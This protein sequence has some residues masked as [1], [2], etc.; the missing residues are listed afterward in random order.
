MTFDS[1][2]FKFADR[3]GRVV[4]KHVYRGTP[5][6]EAWEDVVNVAKPAIG[7]QVTKAAMKLPIEQ[8]LVTFAAEYA[9]LLMRDNAGPAKKVNGLWFGLVE[10][11]HCG[12][13][14]FSMWAPYIS[15][16]RKFKLKNHDWPCDPV[17]FVED[18]WAEN[19]PMV[20]LSS[21]RKKFSQRSWY[22]DVC[23]VEPLHRL[24]VAHFARACP[25]PILLGKSKSRGIGCGFDAGD[26][27]TIGVVDAKGFKP[28]KTA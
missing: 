12:S 22:I 26:L 1:M 14:G 15:G 13:D 3:S 21:L 9:A 5:L 17:W 23:L 20:I 27:L 28:H 2:N 7:P 4:A 18:R 8:G 10:L 16:S 6:H 24:Y 19:E 25:I 11:A